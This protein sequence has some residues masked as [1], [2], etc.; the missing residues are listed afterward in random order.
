MDKEK[1]ELFVEALFSLV[2]GT[3]AKTFKDMKND[4]MQNSQIIFKSMKQMDEE[5]RAYIKEGIGLFMKCAWSNVHSDND[6]ANRT[7]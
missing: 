5:T 2:A 6:R 4:W 1:R 3:N 7:G